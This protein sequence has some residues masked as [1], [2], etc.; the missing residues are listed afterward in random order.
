MRDKTL[1]I[2]GTC[3][4]DGSNLP[5]TTCAVCIVDGSGSVLE[6]NETFLQTLGMASADMAGQSLTLLPF[7]GDHSEG[8]SDDIGSNNPSTLW[9]TVQAGRHW[10]GHCRILAARGQFHWIQATASPV[11][12]KRGHVRHA[13]LTT[14]RMEPLPHP[15]S[16]AADQLAAVRRSL[17][18]AEFDLDAVLLDA[19]E[20]YLKLFGYSRDEVIGRHHSM[21]LFPSDAAA[22]EYNAF[23]STLRAGQSCTAQMKRRSSDGREIWVQ[24]SYNPVLDQTGRPVKVV[25]FATDTTEQKMLDADREGQIQAIRKSLAVAEFTVDGYLLD[26]NEKFLEALGYELN[27]VRGAHHRIFVSADEVETAEYRQFW[28][29]LRKGYYQASQFRRLTKDGRDVWLEATYNPVLTPSGTPYKIVKLARDV[30][31]IRRQLQGRQEEIAYAASHDGLTGLLN[32]SGLYRTFQERLG[33]YGQMLSVLMIDLDGFKPVNDTFG[34]ATGDELLKAVARRLTE[35]VG[36]GAVVARLGGDEFAI[37]FARRH[38]AES[39][40]RDVAAELIDAINAP[41]EVGGRE[42]FI[43]ASIGIARSQGKQADLDAL[44]HDADIA[45]Y[46]VKENG[47]RGFHVF[48]RDLFDAVL[49]NQAL[50]RDLEDALRHGQLSIDYQPIVD[51]NSRSVVAVEAL[52]RWHHPTRG[53]VPPLDFIRQAEAS[54]L[55]E[56]LGLFLLDQVIKDMRHIP[57]PYVISMNISPSQLASGVFVNALLARIKVEGI[58]PGRFEL[59]V[60]ETGIIS[61]KEQVM[62]DLHRIKEAGLSIALDDFGTGYSS[63]SNLKLFP[64]D[65]I[66]I[67]RAFIAD[68][69][70]NKQSIAIVEAL[71]RLANALNITVTAEGVEQENQ[72][73]MLAAA[74]CASVQGFLFGRRIAL[75]Q[76]ADFAARRRAAGRH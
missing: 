68:I 49:R 13:V 60:T 14:T 65:R 27:E 54:G 12:D 70:D 42:I 74:G 51:T 62:K 2:T 22:A 48:D 66:K 71:I 46:H 45:L 55:I 67:D 37:T 4:T 7:D 20:N 26:A 57:K 32:R 24:A 36:R 35:V 41:F 50:E 75:G 33:H 21:F 58:D 1:R 31:D 28:R 52:M 61:H 73:E 39:Q 6:A 19:N 30:T 23:W 59:E 69:L 29:R 38:S 3:P 16:D 53:S 40:L 34:H 72:V 17:S 5:V 76:D 18:V 25:K 63:L 43:G 9:S 10:A 8:V 64:F 11:Y 56:P 44:L 47:K 15:A